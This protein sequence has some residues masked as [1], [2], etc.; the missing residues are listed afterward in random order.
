MGEVSPDTVPSARASEG[1]LDSW[2]EIAAY[3][4]RDVTTVQ[5]WEKREAM[6]V[7]RHQHDR[8]GSVY[9]YRSELDAWAQGRKLG[10]SHENG[11]ATLAPPPPAPDAPAPPP[12]PMTTAH[13][14]KRRRLALLL[15]AAALCAVGAG[16]WL[17]RTEFFWR[18]PIADFRF[19]TLTGFDGSKQ[20]AAISRDGHFVAFL[21]D[22]DGPMDVWVTQV[23][24]GQFH[25]LTNGALPGMANPAVRTLG[26][27]PDGSLITCW[28]RRQ[29]GTGASDI[30]VWS[31]P[32]LGGPPKPYLA[33]VAELDWSPDGARLAYHTPAPGDPLFVSSGGL[34]TA[35]RPI[36]TAP[37][38]LHSH[39][40]L[41]SPD[42]ASLYF[43]QGELPDKLDI[44]RI[45]STGGTAQRMTSENA[46]VSYPVFLDRRTLLYLA[47][48]ADGSGPWLHSMDVE[49][50][51]AHRLTARLDRFTSLGATADGRRLV[52]TMASAK[53]SLWRL[54][55]DGSPQTS[56]V[57]IP[58][59]TGSV[60]T[61][62]LAQN[63][64]LYVSATGTG[65]SLW[66][67]ANGTST[68][69]WHG[70]ETQIFGAPALS[71]DGRWLAFSASRHGQRL[72]YVMQA[73]G[74]NARLVTDSLNLQGAPAWAPDARSILTAVAD[75]GVPKL[76]RVPI[77]GHPPSVFV[78]DYSIDPA[79]SPD[80]RFL[81]Y[82]GPD[83]G[84]TF[85]VRAVSA[86]AA[87]YALPPL[88][89]TRGARHLAFL[90]GGNSLVVLR[91]EMQH[92]DL[93]LIDLKTGAERQ[94]THLPPDFD[95]RD[96]DISPDGHEVV[97]ERT[98]ESSD[99]VLL[100]LPRQ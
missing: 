71:P 45:P 39:F 38:G 17:Q 54:R 56:A 6:P 65:E 89:L 46:A 74:A 9:A 43:V 12:P 95:T 31:V 1:R 53:T 86:E 7:H 85:A 47:S 79:W 28:V 64:L 76:Y 24:S 14:V 94:L 48:D 27:T 41:W 60:S 77:D 78:S 99:V 8:M 100:D 96:F 34:Q 82:T 57:P 80:G 35:D 4:S 33:G 75:H 51:I 42:A 88:Q 5:R 19:H 3:F 62:R 73:D 44:W 50:R 68:E 55:V 90:P 72:L 2:K 13:L 21:S 11:A 23:G 30:G 59:T 63:Y 40:P 83:I 22:R 15:A 18:N 29:G 10:P 98:L 97:L 36:F 92:K 67:T 66:K 32:T 37:A 70:E 91:G 87:T 84:T 20:S 61:P 25:N 93:W 52:A 58:L 26:F 16:L 49:R 69:L 81:V